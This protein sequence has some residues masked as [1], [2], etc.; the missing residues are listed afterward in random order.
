MM[1]VTGKMVF[2]ENITST[3]GDNQYMMNLTS[4]AKGVY[5]LSLKTGDSIQKAKIVI[6]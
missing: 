2:S 4:I 5:M 1:D 3:I 6:E